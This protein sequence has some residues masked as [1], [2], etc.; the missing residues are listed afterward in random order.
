MP[1][2]IEKNGQLAT[3]LC[4]VEI[5][6]VRE[7]GRSGDNLFGLR[8]K[9]TERA[10]TRGQIRAKHREGK[11][12]YGG[13]SLRGGGAEAPFKG[14]ASNKFSQGGMHRGLHTME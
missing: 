12:I 5:C 14:K 7:C 1:R 10:R 3:R 4:S 2:Y 13:G 8:N 6:S 9:I 11:E